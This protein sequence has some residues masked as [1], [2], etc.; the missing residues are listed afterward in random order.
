MSSSKPI[1]LVF[2]VSISENKYQNT[3]VILERIPLKK[4]IAENNQIRELHE[5]TKFL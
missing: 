5:T 2:K 3:R 4:I 1:K